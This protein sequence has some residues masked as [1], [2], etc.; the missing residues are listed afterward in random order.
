M[1]SSLITSLNHYL[2]RQRGRVDRS[3]VHGNNYRGWKLTMATLFFLYKR[4][5]RAFFST[6]LQTCERN[7]LYQRYK[8]SFQIRSELTM[9][10]HNNNDFAMNRG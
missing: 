2:I 3:A 8:W 1:I 4:H 10:M 7:A 6:W 5:F 9:S